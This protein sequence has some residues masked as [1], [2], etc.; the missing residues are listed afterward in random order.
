MDVALVTLL[1][2][3]V[4]V[5]WLG[6]DLGAFYTSQFVTKAD[7]S[8]AERMLA[9]KVVNNVDLAPRF[10]MIAT[11]PTGLLLADVKGWLD[12]GPVWIGAA[13]AVG[14]VWAWL[15]WTIH[16]KHGPAG[17][18]FKRVD[19]IWRWLLVA[20][21]LGVLGAAW[22]QIIDMPWFIAL[23]CGLLAATILLGLRIRGQ[24]KAF[25]PA[26][27]ALMTT[28]STPEVEATLNRSMGAAR[29]TVMAI[30][31]CLIAAAFL[32]LWTPTA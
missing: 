4:L 16:V 17:D 29:P 30:W 23:K 10:S 1:H 24:L 20:A 9:A 12:L 31:A 25:G 3:L 2:V 21:L 18:P 27:G 13:F 6:G 11:L 26:L 28:G 7:L 5:Y 19:E 8:P 15:A 14:A 22:A 32:G